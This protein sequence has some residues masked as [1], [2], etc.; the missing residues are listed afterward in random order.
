MVCIIGAQRV[1]DLL[2]CC[3]CAALLGPRTLPE[4]RLRAGTVLSPK[5]KKTGATPTHCKNLP[6]PQRACS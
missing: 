3:L 6:L 4:L 1:E 2:F 5:P